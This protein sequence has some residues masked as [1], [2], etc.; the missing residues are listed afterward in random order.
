[1][2]SI[3]DV[4]CCVHPCSIRGARAIREEKE[5]RERTRLQSF[6]SGRLHKVRFL[7]FLLLGWFDAWLTL[8]L[9]PL[10]NSQT[11][12]ASKV[13]LRLALFHVYFLRTFRGKGADGKTQ[14]SLAQA[15]ARLDQSCGRPSH[16]LQMA[17]QREVKAI[18]AVRTWRDFFFRLGVPLPRESFL[19][20]WLQRSLVNSARK[21]YHDPE[22]VMAER[23]A[24]QDERD[25]LKAEAKKKFGLGSAAD[26]YGQSHSARK[27]IAEAELSRPSMAPKRGTRRAGAG[28]C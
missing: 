24:A 20:D 14:I 15:Q 13:S 22:R 23:K 18:K 12:Q 17:F 19:V 6:D 7:I 27:A 9:A 28:E 1:M 21:N 4:N 3:P 11:F 2:R 16:A 8:C 25:R 10:V 5:D 26:D